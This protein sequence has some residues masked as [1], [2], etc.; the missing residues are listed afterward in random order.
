[1]KIVKSQIFFFIFIL[2]NRREKI[3]NLEKKLSS[4]YVMF[5]YIY[6][7][8]ILFV[9]SQSNYASTFWSHNKYYYSY[10]IERSNQNRVFLD[11][12]PS[13]HPAYP[14]LIVNSSRTVNIN[15]T[16]LFRVRIQQYYYVFPPLFVVKLIVTRA[17]PPR[18]VKVNLQTT[19]RRNVC[20]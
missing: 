16:Y 9:M 15:L 6:V 14:M 3:H 7:H 5:D 19:A 4:Q 11:T 20:P 10:Y 8:S 13:P 1:M 18:H 17:R 2:K 12:L